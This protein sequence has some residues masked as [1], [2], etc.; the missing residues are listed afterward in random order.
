MTQ[1][2]SLPLVI[3]HVIYHLGVGGLENGLVNLINHIPKDEYHHLIICLT[4]SSEFSQRISNDKVEIIELHKNPG[5]DWKA[6]FRFYQILQQR[7]VDIVHTRNLAA[8]E[9]QLPAFLAGVKGRIHSEHGWDVFDPEGNNRKYQILRR[10]LSCL[11]HVLIPLSRHI[12][13][14]LVEKVG[15]P[16]NKI[17]RICN[18]VDDNKFFSVSGAELVSDC[19]F[20][21]NPDAVY[22][23]TVG[24]MHGVKDQITL[25]RAFI[26]LLET[27]PELKGQVYLTLVG[28]GPL[29]QQAESMLVESGLNQFVWLPGAR[30]DIAKIMQSLTVFVLPS[31][32]EGISNTILEAMATGLPVIA[33]DVGG[34]SELVENDRNGYLVPALDPETMS[35]AMFKMLDD[36]EKTRK[37]G[38]KSLEKV[39]EKFSIRA[40]VSQYIKVYDSIIANRK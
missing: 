17:V 22:F 6:M 24:R 1:N 26:H 12:E 3:A 25:V 40:M 16:E 14:Y 18:G 7:K 2:S 29:K 28:D 27:K 11:I 23:G 9:Y 20:T 34:N 4:E 30:K 35:A 5:Q 10:V 37:M 19:P 13:N 21:K 8:I 38:Q 32:A 15:V 33:T 39:Q 36:L 31:Q